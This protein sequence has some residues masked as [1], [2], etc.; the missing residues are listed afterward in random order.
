MFIDL[1]NF[2]Q[3]NDQC[4]HSI[5]DDLLIKIS[6]IFQQ[7]LRKQDVLSRFGGDEFVVCLYDVKDIQQLEIICCQL[8][9]QIKQIDEIS[10]FKVEIGASIGAV[11]IANSD[12]IDISQAIEKA[13]RLMYK[14][15]EKNK[16]GTIV[17]SM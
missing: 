7:R 17:H 13:D 11:F 3:T 12:D 5:G 10:G 9:D 16:G 14:V 15:K 6:T 8:N 1:D 2:K 4:G